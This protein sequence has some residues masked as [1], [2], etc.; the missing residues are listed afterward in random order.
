MIK[1]DIWY[2]VYKELGPLLSNIHKLFSITS[3]QG[4]A[5]TAANQRVSSCLCVASAT[6]CTTAASCAC[7]WRGTR[8][9][10]SCAPNSP[11]AGL[12]PPPDHAW[13][14]PKMKNGWAWNV[15]CWNTELFLPFF[16]CVFWFGDDLTWDSYCGIQRRVQICTRNN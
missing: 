4:F 6:A 7:I 5:I 15:V 3:P 8:T 13:V 9:T 11:P 14:C 10:S 2:R 1:P 12:D 16:V